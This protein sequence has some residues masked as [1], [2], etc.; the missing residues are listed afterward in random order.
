[1]SYVLFLLLREF[2]SFGHWLIFSKLVKK[3][4]LILSAGSHPQGVFSPPDCTPLLE[5]SMSF[6]HFQF[7]FSS[8]LYITYGELCLVT[9]PR[10]FATVHPCVFQSRGQSKNVR[11]LLNTSVDYVT[12]RDCLGRKIHR[13]QTIKIQDLSQ[14]FEMSFSYPQPFSHLLPASS[15]R[16]A[17]ST[18]F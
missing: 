3:P 4:S 9:G 11:A 5:S 7:D 13:N 15:N 14:E 17:D 12:E 6:I 16:S 2:A 8:S 1:M 18:R 10:Y